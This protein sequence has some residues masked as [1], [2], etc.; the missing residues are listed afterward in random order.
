MRSGSPFF[1]RLSQLIGFLLGARIFVTLLLALALYV[2]TFFLFNHEES[3]RNFVFDFRVHSIIISALLSI[4]A[5]GIIN[6]FYDQEKDRVTQPFRT[7]LQSFLQQK[8]FL[9][10]YIGLNLL[11]LGISWISSWRIFLF[12]LFYQF[13]MWFYS[14]RLSRMLILNNLTF[15]GLT[16]YPFF[17]MVIYYQTFSLFTLL[18]AGFLFIILIIID[19]VKDTLTK[20]ADRMFGYSTIPNV[21]GKKTAGRILTVLFA[22]LAVFSILIIVKGRSFG[23]MSGYFACSIAVILFC[24]YLLEVDQKNSKFFILNILRLWVVAGVLAMLVDGVYSM[25]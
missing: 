7:R 4:M 1:I 22:V 24:I 8:Y 19:I 3:L 17:G 14:H 6:Q 21:L 20:N 13:L 25:L 16:L 15:V 12:F 18:L 2:S 5:G 9:F 23:I 11:S 10:A